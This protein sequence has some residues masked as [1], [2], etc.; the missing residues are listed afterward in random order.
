[1][2]TQRESALARTP[3]LE[4]CL[5]FSYVQCGYCGYLILA[6]SAKELVD[7]EER[8]AIECKATH[9]LIGVG[10]LRVPRTEAPPSPGHSRPELEYGCIYRDREVV[11]NVRNI[12]VFW[13]IDSQEPALSI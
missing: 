8:H 12:V 1:M 11:M 6:G 2:H 13:I 7:E 5:S 3:V 10:S 9:G 4:N